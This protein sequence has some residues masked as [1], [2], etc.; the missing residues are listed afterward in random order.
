MEINPYLSFG[1]NCAEAFKFYE[2]RLG[3]KILMSMKF[4]D[5]PMANDGPPGWGDKIIHIRL[6]LDGNIIMGSDSPP[7]YFQ[8]NHGFALS[9]GVHSVEEAEKVFGTLSENG[10]VTMDLQET[11]WAKRFGMVT[12]QFGIHWMVNYEKRA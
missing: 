5:S 2:E 9:V 11:F 3:G 1:G 7:D 8:G 4:G 6:E 10:K 12:D